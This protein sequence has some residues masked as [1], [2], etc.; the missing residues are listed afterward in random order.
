MVTVDVD[1]DILIASLPV[2]LD[3]TQFIS[4]FSMQYFHYYM[5]GFPNRQD[6][7]GKC[8][9]KQEVSNQTYLLICNDKL[10]NRESIK[11]GYQQQIPEDNKESTVNK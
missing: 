6:S 7:K 10:H 11:H 8:S 1:R 3:C 5:A 9:W 4:N 2:G